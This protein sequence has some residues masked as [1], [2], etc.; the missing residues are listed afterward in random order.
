M[1]VSRIVARVALGWLSALAAM[2]AFLRI[3]RRDAVELPHDELELYSVLEPKT[4]RAG[5]NAIRRGT[6][7]TLMGA[8]SLDLR[9]AQAAT[10]GMRLTIITLLGSTELTVPDTW[11][12]TLR[13][14]TVAGGVSRSLADD[15]QPDA[16]ALDVA[17]YTLLGGLSVTARPVLRTAEGESG[18]GQTMRR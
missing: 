12:V 13:T 10:D 7:C 11:N 2:A 3:S 4:L 18:L 17:A 15:T 5:R 9:R 14:R 16:P 6:V 8:G 1:E